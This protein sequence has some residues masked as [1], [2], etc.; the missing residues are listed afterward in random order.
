M[1]LF[2]QYKGGVFAFI[3]ALA[4]AVPVVT[5]PAAAQ[6][7]ETAGTAEDIAMRF[8]I[9]SSVLDV[10]LSPN[11]T[12]LAWVAP[13]PNH[14]EILKVI[15]LERDDGVQ[16]I[17]SNTMIHADITKCDW[18]TN[19][20][21]LCKLSG[22]AERRDD[23]LLG[24]DRLFSLNDDGSDV[25]VISESNLRRSAR[26]VQ[27]GGDVIA[28]DVE[29]ETGQILV[30]RDWTPRRGTLSRSTGNEG[31]G[32]ERL[33]ITTSEKSIEVHPEDRAERYLADETGWVRLQERM[34]VDHRG[35]RTGDRIYLVRERG[36]TRWREVDDV[37][38]NG[39]VIEDY[40]PISVNAARNSIYA[41]HTIGGY[42]AVIEIPLDGEGQAQVVASRD[43]VDVLG[44]I[45]IG[46]QRRVVGV[47]Y[48]TEKRSVEYFDATL[49]NLAGGLRRALP[50]TPLISIVGANADESR[51]LLIASSDTQP[52]TVYLYDKASRQLEPLLQMRDYLVDRPMGQMQAITFPAADGTQIPGYLTLPP[53]SDG[54]NLPA[55]VLPHGGP[56]ARDYWGF[57]W[58][59][60]F[61]TARGYAVLQPNYRGSAG[62]G[63]AWFGR[64]GYQAWDVAIGDVNDAGRWLVEKGFANPDQLAIVGWSYGGYAALQS[65]VVDP[66]LYKAVVA[67]A[68]VTDLEYLREDAR[69]YTSFRLRNEQLG[70]GPHIREGSPRRHAEKFLAPVI[71]FHGT[72]DLN[73]NVRH[74]Q[75]MADALQDENKQVT[76]VE[77]EDLEHSLD[78]SRA[79]VEMLGAIDDFLNEALGR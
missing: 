21:L 32:V 10:S 53:G 66:D 4:I 42:R 27:D 51:I 59:V 28:L 63:E 14:T 54:T 39:Q 19:D 13:G 65:Q 36:E 78:D 8:G 58:L 9:R 35:Y 46:R 40:R 20:R 1:K 33:D 30:T 31:L 11:G 23:V 18:V 73:V 6:E 3:A 7:A 34:P 17:M 67:I 55:V 76:Y 61:F 64:N 12:K 25:Q 47:S 49:A 2:A 16:M 74:S 15:D 75:R 50:E 57:D 37:Y 44:L 62:Y 56:A 48:A 43:D 70:D 60:Q 45:R 29:G 72:R 69:A 68:P 22:V 79:R 38:L 71:L 41:Y 26:F 5:A 77:F 24:Y 52:G